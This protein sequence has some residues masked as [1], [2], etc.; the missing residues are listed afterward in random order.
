MAAHDINK[1]RAIA[2]DFLQ[3]IATGDMATIEAKL[4][5][6]AIYWVQGHGELTRSE[7]IA[8]LSQTISRAPIRKMEIDFVTAEEDRVAV[9][10]H[11]EFIFAEGPYRNTYHFLFTVDG[12]R[13]VAAREYL[14]TKIVAQ[15]FAPE[16]T[17]A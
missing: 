13:I 9:A 14:D 4:A 1:N 10:A 3:A 2:L 8:A 12:E 7:V 6:N 15:F 5:A 11:S 16:Q 17:L